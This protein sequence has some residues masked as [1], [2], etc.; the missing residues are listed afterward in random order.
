MRDV[1]IIGI[2]QTAVS[3][4]WDLCLRDLGATAAL[5]ALADAHVDRADAI[6][7]GNMLAGELSG[8]ENLATL[9]ADCTGLLPIEALRI[10]AACA[11][12]GA[13]VRAAY[14][15]V[16][17]GAHDL[18][19]AVGVE[20]MTDHLT[21]G[22]TAALATA[23]DA[24]YEAGHGISFVALNALLMRRYMHEHGARHDDFAAF[25][26]NSHENAVHNENAMY[27]RAISSDEYAASTVVADPI[28]ILDSAAICDGAAALL[29]CPMQQASAFP[30]PPIRIAASTVATDTL[31]LAERPDPLHWGAIEVSCNKAYEQAGVGLSDIDLYEAHDAFTIVS[32]LSLEAAGFARPGEGVHFARDGR[33]GIAGDI[34]LSTMGGL[35]GRGHPIG[36]SGVYQVLEVV[37]QLRGDAG[38]LQ[39]KNAHTGMAQSVGGS[40]SVAVTHILQN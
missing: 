27:R 7:V 3:E 31:G 10:E 33:I 36:A 40:G 15:A 4:H 19:L 13:A 16:A 18:V 24:D 9:I 37:K 17:S 38:P 8:Q 12:G 23:A 28:T 25:S 21:D 39:V 22:I 14:T 20:K 2:G 26:I 35:K 11:A 32:A 1:G 34:P 29:L 6:Y 30:V 5:R